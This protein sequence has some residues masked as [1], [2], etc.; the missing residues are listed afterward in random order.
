MV[1]KEKF[2]Q[3]EPE[4]IEV[5]AS[6]GEQ[7]L[8]AKGKNGGEF[9]FLYNASD[10]IRKQFL[11]DKKSGALGPVS[12]EEVLKN[13]CA[14]AKKGNISAFEKYKEMAKTALD[15]Y[16]AEHPEKQGQIVFGVSVSYDF[17]RQ[18]I[19]YNPREIGVW[20]KIEPPSSQTED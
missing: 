5:V 7:R 1:E 10:M 16:L 11:E 13:V 15:R 17:R 4:K 9:R 12:S 6:W 14:Q 20:R 8:I 18:R 3:I 19:K 2:F